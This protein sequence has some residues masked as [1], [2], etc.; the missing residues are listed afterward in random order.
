MSR[1]QTMRDAETPTPG[2][3]QEHHLEDQ[4]EFCYSQ[5]SIPCRFRFID[6]K[7]F[8]ELDLLKLVTFE[9]LDHSYSCISYVWNGLNQHV[10]SPSFNVQGV[11]DSHPL[12]IGLLRSACQL[13]LLKNA[14]Y[15]WLDLICIVQTDHM[16]KN[17]QIKH[18]D[19]IYKKCVCCL[20][21]PG[22]LQ[23]LADLHTCEQTQWAERHWTLQ[24]AVLPIKVYCMYQWRLC[25]GKISDQAK[26]E[27]LNSK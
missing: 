25:S 18:M 6:C 19:E 2:L 26:L 1:Q 12:N 10:V 5:Q 27:K 24:E 11:R 14:P 9:N 22:G 8:C 7:A 17:W 4:S 21:I 3:V 13:S 20:V 16:D 15:M 23:R